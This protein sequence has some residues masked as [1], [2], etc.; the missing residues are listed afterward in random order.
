MK[1][2]ELVF[3]RSGGLFEAQSFAVACEV[4]RRFGASI[5]AAGTSS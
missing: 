1:F 2:V 5:R 3:M 4:S